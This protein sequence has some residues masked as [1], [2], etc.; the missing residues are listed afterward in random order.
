MKPILFIT[1]SYPPEVCGVGDYLHKI[2]CSNI[3]LDNNWLL[4]YKRV[5]GIRYLFKY[6]REIRSISVG[7]ICLQYPT[8][9]YGWSIVPHLLCLLCRIF[10]N[11]KFV[12]CLHEFSNSSL[13][14]KIASCV[15]LLFASAVIFTTDYEKEY[16]LKFFPFKRK[17]YFVIK[18]CSNILSSSKVKPYRERNIDLLYFG[19]IRPLKGIEEFFDIIRLFRLEH[20]SL[21]VLLMG[22]VPSEY[23]NYYS[24]VRSICEKL[25][26]ELIL[27]KPEEEVASLLNNTKF[28]LLPF[29][30][31]ISERRGSFLACISNG[32]NV[33]TKRGKYSTAEIDKVV[34]YYDRTSDSAKSVK[35]IMD[36]SL[37]EYANKQKQGLRYISESIPKSWDNVSLNYLQVIL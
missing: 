11:R 1:G 36:F 19:H 33:I 12:V 10:L 8:Q 20:S 29:P 23:N 3:A 34:Y 15:F 28:A 17:K 27:N 4:F 6:F 2:M 16:A 14:S 26:I 7:D 25:E 9:G 32:V 5:W 21:R 30:D 18:I 13:K 37:E 31:G 35:E 22:Q 24:E